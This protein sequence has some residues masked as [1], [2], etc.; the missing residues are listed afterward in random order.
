MQIQA[1]CFLV[2]LLVI[3]SLLFLVRCKWCVRW[4]VDKEVFFNYFLNFNQFHLLDE[5][6]DLEGYFVDYDEEDDDNDYYQDKSEEDVKTNATGAPPPTT[7]GDG[8]V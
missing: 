2:T 1:I 5:N 6:V 8:Q 7:N 4:S 3:S